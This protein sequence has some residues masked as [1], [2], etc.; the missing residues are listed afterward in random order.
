LV[1]YVRRVRRFVVVC[2]GQLV[3]AAPA[4]AQPAEPAQPDTTQPPDAGVPPTDEH[5]PADDQPPETFHED[6]EFGPVILIEAIEITG[7]TA[8]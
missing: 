8:T 3:L 5:P 7:N 4:R 6:N 1:R 2:L